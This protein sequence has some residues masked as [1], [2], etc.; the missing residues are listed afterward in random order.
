MLGGD[1]GRAFGDHLRGLLMP[2][3]REGAR[4]IAL[5]TLILGGLAAAA[6]VGGMSLLL[7]TL[8]KTPIGNLIF[9]K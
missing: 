2:I 9:P 7:V 5:A 6:V 3:A 4:E 1:G 8:L